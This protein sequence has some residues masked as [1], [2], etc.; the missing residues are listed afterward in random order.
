V[1]ILQLFAPICV[2]ALM[3]IVISATV[4]GVL[5]MLKRNDRA[6]YSGACSRHSRV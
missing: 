2:G 3:A 1:T 4:W 6:S 5:E